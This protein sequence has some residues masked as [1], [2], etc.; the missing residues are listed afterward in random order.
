[1]IKPMSDNRIGVFIY[2]SIF[3]IDEIIFKYPSKIAVREDKIAILLL[4]F[5]IKFV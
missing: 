1:M 2:S 5:F 4:F 3:P